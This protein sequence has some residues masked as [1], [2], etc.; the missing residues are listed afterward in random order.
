MSS[1]PPSA[2]A[3]RFPCEGGVDV[4]PYVLPIRIPEEAFGMTVAEYFGL[5]EQDMD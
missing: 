1:S 3:S 2:P 4:V 5:E